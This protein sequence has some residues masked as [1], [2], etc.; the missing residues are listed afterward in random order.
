[1][2]IV[3]LVPKAVAKEGTSFVAHGTLPSCENCILRDKCVEKLKA[4]NVY[5]VL[6]VLGSI[7][8]PCP[9]HGSVI[10]CEVEEIGTEIVIE[11][12]KAFDGAII[13]YEPIRCPLRPCEYWQLCTGK[14]AKLRRGMKVKIVKIGEDVACPRGLSLVKVIVK[15]VK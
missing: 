14:R 12:R 3:A 8:H 4:G 2:G 15:P 10:A 9:I 7:E 13:K 1:M 5:K 11:K 6:R